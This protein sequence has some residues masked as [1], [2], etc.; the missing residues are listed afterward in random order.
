V[1]IAAHRGRCRTIIAVVNKLAR[2]VWAVWRA[3]VVCDPQ[4]PLHAAAEVALP[5]EGHSRTFDGVAGRTGA[6]TSANAVDRA[7]PCGV[8]RRL[9][10]PIVAAIF[11][12]QIGNP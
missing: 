5:V 9:R 3:D 8:L 12:P 2:I 11:L 4:R 6:E 1:S 10:V 7:G